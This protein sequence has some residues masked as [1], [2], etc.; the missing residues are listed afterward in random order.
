MIRRVNIYNH[1]IKDLILRDFLATD[2]TVLANERTF[3]AYI[4]TVLSLIVAGASFV[5]FADITFIVITGYL[6]FP[7]A[8]YILAAGVIRFFRIRQKLSAIK[9]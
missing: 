1:R 5:T 6:F 7:V 8:L 3:L 9:H 2:R 4:R